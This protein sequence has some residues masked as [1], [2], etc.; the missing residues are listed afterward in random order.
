M[1]DHW[2]QLYRM[3]LE[4]HREDMAVARQYRLLKEARQAAEDQVAAPAP[5]EPVRFVAKTSTP[6]PRRLLF[7]LGV[8]LSNW[9]CRL[10]SRYGQLQ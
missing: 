7:T 10:Q 1:S 3:A 6:A 4:R 5:A 8:H 9:G 2:D